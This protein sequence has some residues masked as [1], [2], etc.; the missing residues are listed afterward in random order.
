MVNLVSVPITLL[1]FIIHF[2]FGLLS[3]VRQKRVLYG[4]ISV[5]SDRDYTPSFRYFVFFSDTRPAKFWEFFGLYLSPDPED[6]ACGGS[7]ITPYIIQTAAHC[8]ATVVNKG[9]F[10]S[11]VLPTHI[12]ENPLYAYI[13]HNIA[14]DMKYWL[15]PQVYNVFLSSKRPAKFWQ[16]WGILLNPDPDDLECGGSLVTPYIIQTAAHCV[17]YAVDEGRRFSPIKTIDPNEDPLYAY[18]GHNIAT[19]M[20]YWLDPQLFVAFPKTKH[21]NFGYSY[22]SGWIHDFGLI[23][24]KTN[25]I[26]RTPKAKINYVPA[27]PENDIKS[28]YDEAMQNEYTCLHIGHGYWRITF[29]PS[30]GPTVATQTS[31]PVRWGWRTLM[32]ESD[33]ESIMYP[34]K[35]KRAFKFNYTKERTWVCSQSWKHDTEQE[36]L[37]YHTNRGDS[38]GPVTC[39]NVFFA[40]VSGGTNPDDP[41]IVTFD[42]AIVHVLFEHA[43]EHRARFI[44]FYTKLAF[45]T[46]G[47]L[48]TSSTALIAH[49]LLLL[50]FILNSLVS[51]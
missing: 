9:K 50:A 37:L 25:V 27:Y 23:V 2:E 26:E 24:T 7:L 48:D 12:D 15:D 6:L 17:A 28:F 22:I 14:T 40:V 38:G 35:D 20:K 33:C 46:R 21:V 31:D 1:S 29:D 8:I 30:A 41:D 44:E 47:A 49:S 45:D 11:D 32:S 4:R 51:S 16:F 42:S 3:E 36:N 34:P 19:D 5:R 10:Y 18:I 39:N 43:A 13:G